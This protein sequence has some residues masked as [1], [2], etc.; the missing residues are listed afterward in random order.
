MQLLA[1]F[2]KNSVHR[3]QSHLKFSK[4]E[5]GSEPHVQN[6]FKLCQKL[7]LI[8]LIKIL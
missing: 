6:S 8:M 5:G 1:K 3:V 4:L 2:K 7:H